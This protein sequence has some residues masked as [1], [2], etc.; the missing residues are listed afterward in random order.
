MRSLVLN[1]ALLLLILI[2]IQA[3]NCEG[4]LFSFN[5]E[6]DA[7]QP[8]KINYPIFGDAEN[9]FLGG[10]GV[11]YRLLASSSVTQKYL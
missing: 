4:R 1:W 8:A 5:N 3:T 9:P 7:P 6:D 10:A 11:G 2:S